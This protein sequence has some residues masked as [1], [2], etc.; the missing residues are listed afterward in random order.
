MLTIIADYSRKVWPYFL[1][2]KYEA[3]D[4]F[5][6]WKVM[7]EKQTKKKVKLIRTDN[8]MEF[9]SNEFNDY[10]NDEGIVRH[11][12]ITYTP[13][14]NGVAE[15]MNRT[16]I[17]KARCML[18]NAGMSRRFWAEA[19]YTACYLISHLLFHLIRKLPL[20]YGLVHLLIINS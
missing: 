11:Y 20:R 19:D 5:R 18:S 1:K 10:Y 15:R 17:S 14:Q 6:K 2:H 9:Y 12:I 13:Q 7:I 16:I 8:G 3:F 4:A